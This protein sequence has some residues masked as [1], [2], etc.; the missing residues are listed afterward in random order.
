[1]LG[2]F[3]EK[4]WKG[5]TWSGEVEE[6][7]MAV[8]EDDGRRTTTSGRLR[9]EVVRCWGGAGKRREWVGG[10]VREGVWEEEEDLERRGL[11]A[12]SVEREER[13][14]ED[15]VRGSRFEGPIL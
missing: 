2:E 9:E 14:S 10:A 6:L 3:E 15:E 7:E 11:G 13:K 12:W 5:G 1:M 8:K 4:R